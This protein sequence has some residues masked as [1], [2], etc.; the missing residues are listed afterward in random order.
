MYKSKYLKYKL[1]YLKLKNL[2][3]GF[4]YNS[5][6]KMRVPEF[7]NQTHENYK[8]N[9]ERN[10]N[11]IRILGADNKNID[12]AETANNI[13]KNINKMNKNVP[14]SN[15]FI[16]LLNENSK[17]II[18]IDDFYNIYEDYKINKEIGTYVKIEDIDEVFKDKTGLNDQIKKIPTNAIKDSVFYP[19][20]KRIG[21][22]HLNELMKK[23]KKE[24]PNIKYVFLIAADKGDS[25]L[26]NL[27]KEYGF[28]SLIEGFDSYFEYKVKNV[29]YF[30]KTYRN[31]TIMFGHINDII[32]STNST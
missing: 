30:D 25:V 18:E 32:L 10:F 29:L 14:N 27:Y 31:N 17:D 20:K 6:Y 19:S 7:N 28:F 4:K 21:K 5:Y 26:V 23:Y 1:K 8:S 9:T 12:Y 3:G 2:Y 22:I 15:E 11:T 16:C 13:M 24:N